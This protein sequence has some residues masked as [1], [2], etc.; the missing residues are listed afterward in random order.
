MLLQVNV[1]R[2]HIS[3]K[4]ST[5]QVRTIVVRIKILCHG[6]SSLRNKGIK[7]SL[8]KIEV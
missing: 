2:E 5:P 4:V 7:I 6:I 3:D 8:Q 1:R